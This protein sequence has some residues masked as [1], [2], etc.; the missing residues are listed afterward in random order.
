MITTLTAE[1]LIEVHA[2]GVFMRGTS[3][4][5]DPHTMNAYREV[6]GRR[7]EDWASSVLCRDLTRRSLT[8]G[9]WLEHGEPEILVLA[10]KREEA[11]R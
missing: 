11:Q 10:D 7:G 5:E 6:L 3:P 8:W 9:P 2:E 4:F 1:A